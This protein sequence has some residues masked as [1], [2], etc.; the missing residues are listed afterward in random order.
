MIIRSQTREKRQEFMIHVHRIETEEVEADKLRLKQILLNILSNAVKYTPKGG[1]IVFDITEV[2]KK[3]GSFAQ[4]QFR[5]SDNGQGMGEEYL[6]NLFDPFSREV[7][8]TVNPVSGTGLGMPIAKSL[9]E[10]MGG[11]IHVKSKLGKGTTF[12]VILNFRKIK[13]QEK[14][15][16]WKLQ[17]ISQVLVVDDESESRRYIMDTLHPFGI[18]V[19]TADSGEMAVH[20]AE[21]MVE[22]GKTKSW[23]V[24][25][26]DWKMPGNGWCY[27]SRK[28]ASDSGRE[29]SIT[30]F[31]L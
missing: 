5:I 3:K 18:D 11:S 15:N 14:V 10:L 24:V 1:K 30:A 27:Y 20:M 16:W 13:Y 19:Q 2:P 26:I 23:D 29:N 4:Y 12:E 8:S 28:I 31:C 6:K 7:Q 17:K 21:Q 9:V 25:I 22:T